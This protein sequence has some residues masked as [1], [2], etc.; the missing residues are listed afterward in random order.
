MLD[1]TGH[2]LTA[3]VVGVVMADEQQPVMSRSRTMMSPLPVKEMTIESTSLTPPISRFDSSTVVHS[4]GVSISRY[5]HTQ[6]CTLHSFSPKHTTFDS[7]WLERGS[8]LGSQSLEPEWCWLPS[9]RRSLTASDCHTTSVS[10]FVLVSRT[11]AACL[12]H[13]A[14]EVGSGLE[15]QFQNERTSRECDF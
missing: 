3:V 5:K 14:A 13:V 10:G 9:A 6:A 15:K 4:A 7:P 8:F 2:I 12:A 11:R 1:I